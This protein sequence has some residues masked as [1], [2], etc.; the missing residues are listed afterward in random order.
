MKQSVLLQM[1]RGRALILALLLLG[2]LLAAIVGSHRE[3]RRA[4]SRGDTTA[5]YR[6]AFTIL[7][8][9]A[10]VLPPLVFLTAPMGTRVS[11]TPTE[12]IVGRQRANWSDISHVTWRGERAGNVL[13]LHRGREPSLAVKAYLYAGGEERIVALLKNYLP[14]DILASVEAEMRD[15]E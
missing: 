2:M 6:V 3:Y 1:S 15:S 7:I 8:G 9:L 12:I 5:G 13:M 10:V 14:V 4:A 11:L